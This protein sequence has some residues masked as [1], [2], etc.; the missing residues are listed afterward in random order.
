M[1]RF[2]EGLEGHIEEAVRIGRDNA[3]C[4]RNM[5]EWCQHVEIKPESVGELAMVYELPVGLYSL[6]CPK[7]EFK[8]WS[9]VFRRTFGEFLEEHCT[10]CPHHAPNGDIS[11]GQGIIE[12]RQEEAQEREQSASE[13]AAR[14]CQ[15][16]SDLR[17]QSKEINSEAQPESYQI[18]TYFEMIFSEDEAER[19]IASLRLKDAAML[20]ADLFPEAAIDLLFLLAGTSDYA[21]LTLPICA[22]LASRCSE[23]DPRFVQVALDNIEEILY[24]EHSASILATLGEH[25]RYPLNDVHIQRLLLTQEHSLLPRGFPSSEEPDYS[26]STEVLVRCYDADPESVLRIIRPE[27]Q[28]ENAYVRF[29]LC[30]AIELIQSERPQLVE[31]LL[32]DLVR[33]LELSE[34]TFGG[35]VQPSHKIIS[36]LRSAFRYSAEIVDQALAESMTRV[37]PAVQEDIINVYRGLLF[38][39]DISW[40]ERLEYRNRTEVTE[41]EKIAIQRLLTWAKND[42]FELDVRIRALDALETA[43]DYATTEVLKHFNSLLGYLAILCGQERPPDPSSQILTLYPKQPIHPIAEQFDEMSR[44]QSWHNFKRCL[45]ECLK[46]LCRAKSTETSEAVFDCLK[47]P[48]ANLENEFKAF[49]MTLLGILGRN[50]ALRG[51]VLPLIWHGLMDYES[52]WVRAKAI[53]AAVEMFS[54]YSSSPPA[55]MVDIILVHL[56]DP[57]V[58]VHQAAWRAVTQRLS[59]FDREQAE[60]VLMLLG[61]YLIPYYE[62]KYQLEGICLAI[63]HIGRREKSMK[64]LALRMVEQ[65]FPTGNEHVDQEIA[66]TMTRFCNPSERIAGLVAKNIG[67]FL[68]RYDRDHFNGVGDRRRKLMYE[69]LHQLPVETFQLVASDLFVFAKEVAERDSHGSGPWSDS[70][71]EACYAASLFAHFHAYPYEHKVFETAIKALPDEPRNERLHTFLRPFAKIAAGNASLQKGDRTLAETYFGEG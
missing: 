12:E 15:L 44:E 8:A 7:V 69:W 50:F 38:D 45:Q 24:P 22:G 41:P 13:E 55:N 11:W 47:Q 40:E 66:E 5:E 51:R 1:G 39:R 35:V 26:Y 6:E 54:S 3:E 49:C 29:Q 64:S 63:L 46:E 68:A 17:A 19:K 21:E 33:S 2:E 25:V 27:L 52:A 65:V 23:Y 60:E 30:T 56:R 62:D 32:N 16:R 34:D 28:N 18:L 20:G 59:W 42:R 43:C 53:D 37:R 48:S 36:I 61:G 71:W 9:S 67:S 10:N 14:I 70:F 31:N 58:V 57:M 4:K